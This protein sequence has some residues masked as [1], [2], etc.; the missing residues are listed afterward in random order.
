MEGFYSEDLAYVHHT[1]HAGFVQG[2]APGILAR[3]RTAG[4]TGGRVVDLGCGSGRW[5]AMLAEQ[6][7]PVFGVD[8]SESMI[9]IAR[10]VAPAAAFACASLYEVALP[11]CSAVTAMGEAL[12]Y[13]SEDQTHEPALSA[14]FQKVA[15]ALRPGGMFLFDI[16]VR[17]GEEP[18]R[19][20]SWYAG[21]DW[22]ALVDVDEDRDASRMVRDITVF[23]KEGSRYRRSCERHVVRVLDSGRVR[24]DLGKAGFTVDCGPRYGDFALADRRIAFFA[25]RPESSSEP[26]ERR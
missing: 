3:L 18:M 2:A 8:R 20:R 4:I 12:N 16:L 24:E 5:A 19:Y 13:V 7:Y 25:R 11:P 26:G 22:A 9:R 14:L 21:N 10:S 6:G 23:R 17:G 1:G 15:Q